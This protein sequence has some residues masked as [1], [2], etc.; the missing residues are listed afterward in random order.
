MRS[1]FALLSVTIVAILVVMAALPVHA[2]NEAQTQASRAAVKEFGATLKEQLTTALKAGGPLLAIDVCSKIADD[3]AVRV[4]AKHGVS[5]RRTA[6]RVRNEKNIPD[7]FE[8]E[9]LERFVKAINA[10]EDASGLEHSALT[11]SEA[12]RVFR[13]M[14]AIPTVAEPCLACHGESLRADVQSRLRELYPNDQAI[15]FKAG[16]LR[17]AFSVLVDLR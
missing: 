5:L 2:Q 8:R 3:I 9:T 1:L 7:Q 16:E 17:G 15:G 12:G 11:S 14:K 10:G 4:S 13:Y 6:L